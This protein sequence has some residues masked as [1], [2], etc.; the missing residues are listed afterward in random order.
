MTRRRISPRRSWREELRRASS[1]S[2]HLFCT[3][4]KV[5]FQPSF[6]ISLKQQKAQKIHS[7]NISTRQYSISIYK[8]VRHMQLEGSNL[9]FGLVLQPQLDQGT[10]DLYYCTAVA[11]RLDVE[12]IH[13][14]TANAQRLKSMKPRNSFF[15][16][17]TLIFSFCNNCNLSK[18][19]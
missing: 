12:K 4:K 9:Y 10:T 14:F 5:F 11:S 18:K 15:F 8:H 19:S 16:K 13:Q 6:F 2:H 3:L 7:S 1:S 17:M